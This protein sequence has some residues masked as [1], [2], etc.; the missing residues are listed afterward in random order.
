MEANGRYNPSCWKCGVESWKQHLCPQRLYSLIEKTNWVVIAQHD[1]CPEGK[2]EV[3]GGCRAGRCALGCRRTWKTFPKVEISTQIRR[4]VFSFPG[5]TI[6]KLHRL[7]G[8]K[9]WQVV[10]SPLWRPE[11]QSP[12]ETLNRILPCLFVA[13]GWPSVPAPLDLQ[14][15]TPTAVSVVT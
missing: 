4:M 7:G 3:V 15:V 6:A 2:V 5:S 10:L 11:V 13:S 8:L 9:Q 1:E 12:S 14:L